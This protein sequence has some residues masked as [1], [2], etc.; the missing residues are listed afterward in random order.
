MAKMNKLPG[1]PV[2]FVYLKTGECF[3][4][5]Y[6]TLHMFWE[7]MCYLFSR[8]VQFVGRWTQCKLVTHCGLMT[9]YGIT[10]LGQHWLGKSYGTD[11]E[12]VSS[13]P[14]GANVNEIFIEIQTLS[15]KKMSIG[16][17]NIWSSIIRWAGCPKMVI[18][19]HSLT[20]R[21]QQGKSEGFD[22]CNRLIILLKFDPNHRFFSPCHLEIWLM[23]SKNNRTPLL[24]CFKLC[25]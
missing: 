21:T 17:H 12:L 5:F 6:T 15:S 3:S 10:C 11:V 4:F 7:F 16:R 2:C 20:F 1:G 22:S 23:T 13:G 18:C 24:C 14:R 19:V 8:H 9:P 25:A